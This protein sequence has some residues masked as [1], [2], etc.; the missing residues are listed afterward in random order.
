MKKY[1]VHFALFSLL[2]FVLCSATQAF[3]KYIVFIDLDRCFNEFYKT[4]L[5]DTQLKE[6]ANEYNDERK[7]MVDRYQAMQDEFN[8]L[9]EASGN[10]ALA[11][12]VRDEKRTD[13]EDKL[14]EM[15][16]QQARIRRFDDSR[17]RQIEEQGLRMR[18]RI[19]EEMRERVVQYA[20]S[21]GYAA[22]IDSS[23]QSLNG[24]PLILYAEERYDITESML[25]LLNKG[26]E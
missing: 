19:V 4:K 13:A 20:R 3:E 5:A 2:F 21:Q 24:V 12:S 10:T 14:V 1:T 6:Q 15:R 25:Q 22:I 23:G 16:E 9:K 11:E 17:K 18:K 7:E 8:L 26:K